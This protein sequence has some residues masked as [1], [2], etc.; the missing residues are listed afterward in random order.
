[1]YSAIIG[2]Q[3]QQ[4]RLHTVGGDLP[5]R[6]SILMVSCPFPTLFQFHRVTG[7]WCQSCMCQYDWMW[8]VVCCSVNHRRRVNWLKRKSMLRREGV[9]LRQEDGHVLRMWTV[10]CCSVNHQWEVNWLK[11]KSMLSREGVVLRQEDGH[12]LRMWTV[13]CC[14]M[15]HQWEVNWLKRKSMLR[16]E[17]VVLRREDGDVLRREN[18]YVLR[19]E[20]VDCCVL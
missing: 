15:N 5:H 7:T 16:R 6:L 18:G 3:V 11:R 12:V 4:G 17:D 9:V 10:V 1:M 2:V 20:D 19:S 13:V 14:S 8:T